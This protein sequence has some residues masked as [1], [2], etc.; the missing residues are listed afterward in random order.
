[1]QI[2]CSHIVTN[3]PLISKH[4]FRACVQ[5]HIFTNA[6]QL[7]TVRMSWNRT[8]HPCFSFLQ[9]CQ[10]V[11]FHAMN[12]SK[13]SR[14]QQN[15]DTAAPWPLACSN[16][17]Q[18]QASNFRRT[19]FNASSLPFCILPTSLKEQKC[20]VGTPTHCYDSFTYESHGLS[21]TLSWL[22]QMYTIAP[23]QHEV[24]TKLSYSLVYTSA[25]I[26]VEPQCNEVVG[27]SE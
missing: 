18:D 9:R 21:H 7:K 4:S 19:V 11:H 17:R 23:R 10:E 16:Y 3:L 15:P 1:M 5:S 13:L 8:S 27:S 12:P 2:L 25:S 22:L 14:V 6:D 24:G 20:L 26:T